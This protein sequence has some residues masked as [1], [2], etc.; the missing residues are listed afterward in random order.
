MD[1]MKNRPATS[2]NDETGVRLLESGNG[3][4]KLLTTEEVAAWLGIQKCT[5]EKARS[6]RIG[7][8]PPYIRI[9]RGVRY[10]RADVEGWLRRHSYNVDGSS[11]CP[12]AA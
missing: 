11:A 10:R 2:A 6:T 8:F 3:L 9:G 4:D 1:N 5:L 7:D 12:V